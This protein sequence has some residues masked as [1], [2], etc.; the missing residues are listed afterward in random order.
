MPRNA[1]PWRPIVFLF[2]ALLF[3]LAAGAARARHQ[4][5]TRGIPDGLPQVVTHGGATLGLNVDLHQYDQAQLDASLERIIA[6]GVHYIKQPFYYAGDE[7]YDW[8]QSDELLTAVGEHDLEIAAL[9]DGNPEQNFAP[10]DNPADFASWAGEFARRYGEQVQFYF[11]WDEPN[12]SS[13]WGLQPVNAAEYAAILSQSAEAIRAVDGDAVIVAAPLAPTAETGPNNL[14]DT[15]YLQELYASG[16]NE[17]FD[18][19]AGKPYGFYSGPDDRDVAVDVLNFSRAILLREVM[20]ENGDEH[21]AFFAGNWGWN[22]LPDDWQGPPSIWG[23][24]GAQTRV[25]YTA[26]AL[27][28]ARIE[29]PWMGLMFL[30]TWET[31]ASPE[32][33]RHGFDVAGTSLETALSGMVAGSE[34]A[35]PGFHLADPHAPGQHYEGGWRFSPH[36]G[37]DISQTGDS[38]TFCFWG[39]T[40]GLRIRRADYRA[41]LYV[42]IDGE[43]APDLPHDGQGAALVLTTPD[44]DPA[45]EYLDTVL[46]AENLE[47]GPH[48]MTVEAYRGWDQ[49]ALNGFS[50]GYRPASTQTTAAIA[51]LLLG[52]LLFAALGVL[53]AR[54]VPWREV[55]SATLKHYRGLS[56]RARLFGTVLA[57]TLVALTGWLTWGEQAAGVYRRLGDMG[58]LTLTAAAASLFY[59]APAFI[60]YVAAL[61]LLLF[62]IYARPAWGLALVAF[63]FPFYVQPKPMDGYAF[64]P[65]E[66]FVLLAAAATLLSYAGRLRRRLVATMQKDRHAWLTLLN[67][68]QTWRE[69][70]QAADYAAAFFLLVATASLFFSERLDV[71]SNEWRMVVVEPV[72][73]YGLIRLTRPSAKEMWRIIDAFILGGVVVAVYGLWQYA[74]G[75]NVVTVAGGLARLSSIYGSPNNVALYLGRVLPFLLAGTLIGLASPLRRFLYALALFPVSIAFVLTFSKGGLFLGVP[76]GVGIVILLWLRSTKRPIWP[77]LVGVVLLAIGAAAAIFSVPALAQRLDLQGTTSVLRLSLWQASLNMFVENPFFGVGLDNFLYA[78]RGRYILDSGWEEPHL[79]HPHNIV[80]DFATRLGVAGLIAGVWLLSALLRNLWHLRQNVSREWQPIAIATAGA[81]GQMLAHG[82]VDHSFFLVDLSF[83]FFLLLGLTVW[84]QTKSE[85]IGRQSG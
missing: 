35:Y 83:A 6:T 15:R 33:P 81:L 30:E 65:V 56:E 61:A 23:E 51:A 38:L 7:A 31:S 59:V 68:W 63:S 73:F 77:W 17:F 40:A 67:G 72:L 16:A 18:A 37:A 22:A 64:S 12:L 19:A 45:S 4:Y 71:A 20:L 55:E 85:T 32:D 70:L 3:L 1:P 27:S 14:A 80:L 74:L 82:L 5:L 11:I 58:Q 24:T 9:L 57:A 52:A 76:A 66:V 84:L 47:P 78:Y 53:E 26:D 29:W 46:V 21:K 42:T 10:P 48:V 60:V 28:R 43:P 2:V 50:V 13:H 62:F 44:I 41:R 25:S 54:R 8:S 79:N 49:W 69:Q 34:V 39:T 75:E 36:Y